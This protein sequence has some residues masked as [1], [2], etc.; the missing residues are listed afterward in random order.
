M[1]SGSRGQLKNFESTYCTCIHVFAQN[2]EAMKVIR[3]E[4][5]PPSPIFGH[6]FLVCLLGRGAGVYR[7]RCACGYLC[8]RGAHL[9]SRHAACW[10]GLVSLPLRNVQ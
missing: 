2:S 4:E 3:W 7:H 1:G 6:R 5:P 10:G 8:L 9:P